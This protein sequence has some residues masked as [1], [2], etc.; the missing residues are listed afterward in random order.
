MLFFRSQTFLKFWKNVLF[1]LFDA[2]NWL[3]ILKL[4]VFGRMINR[5]SSVTNCP[6]VD[7]QFENIRNM[8]IL[9]HI[10]KGV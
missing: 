7:I 1:L 5:H 3:K 4:C 6:K 8:L 9:L 10:Y 2:F